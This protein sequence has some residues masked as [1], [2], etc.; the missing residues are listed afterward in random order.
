[1]RAG[2]SGLGGEGISRED[3]LR[4]REPDMILNYAGSVG[5]G[6]LDFEQ[7]TSSCSGCSFVSG[8]NFSDVYLWRSE[9]C[10]ELLFLR[11]LCAYTY[12]TVYEG[13]RRSTFIAFLKMDVAAF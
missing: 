8:L 7:W 1:M 4:G 12:N 13:K 5:D 9:K 11:N 2:G 6:L 3:E 10:G